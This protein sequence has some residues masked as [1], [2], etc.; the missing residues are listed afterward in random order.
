MTRALRSLLP[1]SVWL[2]VRQLCLLP[3]EVGDR[4]RGRGDPLLPPRWLRSAAGGDFTAVG[5][6]FLSHLRDLAGLRPSDHVLEVGCGVGRIARALT[7][8]L[9]PPGEYH[10]FDVLAPAV[11]WCQRHVTRRFPHF[12]FEHVDL[13]NGGYNPRGRLR[14]E[15][16]SFPAADASCDLVLLA[17]VCTHLMPAEVR[18]YLGEA[19]RVLRPGGRVL[20]TFF[21][22]NADARARMTGPGSR[23]HF[24]HAGPGYHTTRPDRP[25]TAVAY[26]EEDV[27][28]WLARAGLRPRQPVAY[29][30]WCGRADTREGQDLLVAENARP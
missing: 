25:E 6:R 24:A 13:R 18:R 15:D 21:L 26:A 7:T 27:R 4:L 10:G 16:F 29:G 19:A 8:F 14:A 17:S 22:L 5:A 20:A 1:A 23:F 28:D 12:R 2:R 30:N 9:A 3:L 11:R